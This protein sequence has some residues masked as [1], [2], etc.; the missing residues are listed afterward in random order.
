MLP[1]PTPPLGWV[2]HALGA[3]VRTPSS[4]HPGPELGNQ[5]RIFPLS[6]LLSASTPFPSVLSSISPPLAY[7]T[8]LSYMLLP[9][10]LPV[11]WGKRS[12]STTSVLLQSGSWETQGH[13]RRAATTVV[14][15]FPLHQPV[16]RLPGNTHQLLSFSAR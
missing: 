1:A 4:P 15:G 5:V 6:P 16:S 13:P 12:F 3:T 8:C 7:P 9:L 11:L 2:D 14:G 10:S